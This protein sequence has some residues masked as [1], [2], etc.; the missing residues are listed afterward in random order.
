MWQ[1]INVF[2]TTNVKLQ[3]W[4]STLAEVTSKQKVNTLAAKWSL[5]TIPIANSY[6]MLKLIA[7]IKMMSLANV[8][9]WQ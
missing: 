2:P 1:W 6:V 5:I 3:M 4:F 8:N 7:Q 9:T